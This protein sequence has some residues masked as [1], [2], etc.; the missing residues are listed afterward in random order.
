LYDA[1]LI[2]GLYHFVHILKSER[3][4]YFAMVFCRVGKHKS[5]NDWMIDNDWI[6]FFVKVVLVC[7]Y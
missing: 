4:N 6:V 1:E 2:L 7:H 5:I 3:L